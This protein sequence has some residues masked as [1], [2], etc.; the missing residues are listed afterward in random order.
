MYMKRVQISLQR[1]RTAFKNVRKPILYVDG[2][3]DVKYLK[4][5]S[6]LLNQETLLG[7]VEPR[8]GRGCGNLKKIWNTSPVLAE[9]ITKKVVLLHDCDDEVPP[10]G[11]GN[12]IR[13]TIPKQCGHPIKK[14]IENLFG[15]AILQKALED[16]PAFI[17]I[18]CE[19]KKTERG[20]MIVI[21]EEW[22]VHENEK[23]NLCNWLCENGTKDDFQHFE[24]IFQLLRDILDLAPPVPANHSSGVGK[25]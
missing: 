16:K 23:T 3:T 4:K 13:Q 22:A 18:E 17:D 10:K 12:L 9:V 5:A 14:G 7:Q 25:G 24:V 20:E 21:P 11:K 2:A 19:H 15:K 6:E 1:I 8:D